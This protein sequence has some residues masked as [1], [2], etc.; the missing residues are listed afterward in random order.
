MAC[1]A[2]L[3]AVT[4]ALSKEYYQHA[5]NALDQAAMGDMSQCVTVHALHLLW[6]MHSL[7][8]FQT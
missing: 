8:V 6:Q 7:F 1:A 4:G 5:I 2:G 3:G